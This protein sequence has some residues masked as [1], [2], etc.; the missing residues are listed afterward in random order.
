M[1]RFMKLKRKSLH[2]F[3]YYKTKKRVTIKDQKWKIMMHKK[4]SKH[5]KSMRVINSVK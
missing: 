2:M 4:S 5:S 3:F 1:I